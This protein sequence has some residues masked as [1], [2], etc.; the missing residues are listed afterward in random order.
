MR[1]TSLA[2]ALIIL[3]LTACV[4]AP[5]SFPVAQRL[6]QQTADA[7]KHML[8]S[9]PPTVV[10]GQTTILVTSAVNLFN[11][12]LRETSNYGRLISEQIAESLVRRGYRVPEVRLTKAMLFK[13]GGEFMISHDLREMNKVYNAQL[14]VVPTFSGIS[15]T[16]YINLKLIRL[17]DTAVVGASD[18]ETARIG[19]Y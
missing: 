4:P 7:V 12:R 13:D 15:H 19:D 17:A 10:P 8:E 11:G 14:V 3:S 6:S 5:A 18:F 1:L 2:A 16:N 9:L